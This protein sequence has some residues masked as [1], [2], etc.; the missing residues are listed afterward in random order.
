MT[1][2]EQPEGFV[3]P[4]DAGEEMRRDLATLQEHLPE[5][6]LIPSAVG[7]GA[8]ALNMAMK[9][10]DFTIIKDGMMYQQKKLEGANIVPLHL[11]MV[12]ETAI[13]IE[14]H[15]LGTSSRIATAV[16][17]VLGNMMAE[18]IGEDAMERAHPSPPTADEGGEG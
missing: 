18:L 8:I 6:T 16:Q 1:A 10:H 14:Q 13:R 11:D 9:Y 12:F 2:P 7:I 15:L 4:D 17:D 3:I 5:D